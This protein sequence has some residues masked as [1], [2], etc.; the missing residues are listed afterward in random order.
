MLLRL[1]RVTIRLSAAVLMATGVLAVG[2]CK[3]FPFKI[4]VRQ[5]NFISQESVDRLTLGMTPEQVRSLMGSPMLI[6]QFHTDRWDYTY[7]FTPGNGSKQQMRR[8]LTVFFAEGKV[9]RVAVGEIMPDPNEVPPS[10]TPHALD[11]ESPPST[12][13]AATK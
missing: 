7:L 8:R 12:K 5:G 2:G 3:G 4:D 10:A 13:P 9:S 1:S 6:D 11:L